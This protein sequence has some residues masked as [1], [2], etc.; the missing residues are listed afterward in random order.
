MGDDYDRLRR[1]IRVRADDIGTG[2]T[3]E[4]LVVVRQAFPSLPVAYVSYVTEFGWFTVSSHEVIGFGADVPA[5]LDLMKVVAWERELAYPPMNPHLLPLE[6]NGAG[7][8]YCL[9]AEAPTS[10]VVFWSHDH[11]SGPRQ[12]PDVV[13]PTFV[14]WALGLF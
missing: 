5:H 9:D 6:S 3:T 14:D 10:P 2:C 8:H 11:P 4:E 13:A 7:D 12:T 1:L